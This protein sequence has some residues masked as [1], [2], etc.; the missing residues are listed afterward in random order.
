MVTAPLTLGSLIFNA[1]MDWTL[2]PQGPHVIGRPPT[3]A[4]MLKI[5][6]KFRDC[7]DPQKASHEECWA[8]AT[9]LAP[10]PD[11]MVS[12]DQQRRFIDFLPFGAGTYRTSDDIVRLWYRV[13]TDGLIVA[14]F[15]IPRVREEE[16][17]TMVALEDVDGM[18][19]SAKFAPLEV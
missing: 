6:S 12:E 15:S 5:S 2:Y 9:K 11:G 1:P 3:R 13:T 17:N 8:I 14:F 18:I 19:R 7:V 16:A 4:G 10:S